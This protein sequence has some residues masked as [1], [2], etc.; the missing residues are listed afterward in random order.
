[1]GVAVIGEQMSCAWCRRI[2]KLIK[3]CM[4]KTRKKKKV[5]SVYVFL[6]FFSIHSL[7]LLEVGD[8]LGGEGDADAVHLLDLAFSLG[9]GS[10]VRS[11]HL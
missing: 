9:A 10:L 4:G 2:E 11:R 5:W 6:F 8:V 3:K 7:T 1:M